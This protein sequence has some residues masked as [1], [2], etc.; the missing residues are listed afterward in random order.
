MGGGGGQYNLFS[1]D[2][3]N[4]RQQGSLVYI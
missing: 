3:L 4:T 2:F 1:I